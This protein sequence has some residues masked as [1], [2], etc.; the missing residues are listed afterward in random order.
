MSSDEC[1]MMQAKQMAAMSARQAAPAGP[2]PVS[3]FCFSVMTPWSDERHLLGMQSDMGIGLFQCDD[4]KVYSDGVYSL[5]NASKHETHFLPNTSLHANHTTI[6]V[7]AWKK[8]LDDGDWQRHQWT[9]KLD[10]DTVFFP[11]RFRQIV[12]EPSM[13]QAATNINGTYLKNCNFHNDGFALYGPIEAL[14]ATALQVYR[15]RS[16]ECHP[17]ETPWEDRYM[18][19]CLSKLGLSAVPAE[20]LLGFPCTR[21]GELSKDCTARYASFH[22][23]KNIKDWRTCHENAS[24]T[25]F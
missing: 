20:S 12:L 4:F 9:L 23:F 6:F 16:G 25:P 21:P 7:N 8:V 24:A 14:S 13:L 18:F 5:G 17:S 10:P 15:H 3:I 1:N 11:A 22:P 2:N 19:A